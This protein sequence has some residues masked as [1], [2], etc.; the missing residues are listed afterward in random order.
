MDLEKLE[1]LLEILDASRFRSSPVVVPFTKNLPPNFEAFV[2]DINETINSFS[3]IPES[4]KREL[5]NECYWWYIYSLEYGRLYGRITSLKS[6]LR[7]I[8][9]RY[10]KDLTG[11]DKLMQKIRNVFKIHCEL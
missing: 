10:R 1:N 5:L 9:K 6:N 2:V 4:I 7:S 11:F 8:Y 3:D